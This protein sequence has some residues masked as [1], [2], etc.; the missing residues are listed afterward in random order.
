MSEIQAW[1]GDD[2]TVD[3]G[4]AGAREPRHT[5][6]E[7][8][9]RGSVIGRY[10][11]LSRLG[12][13]GM[14]VVYAAYDPELDRKV[15]LKLLLVQS[16]GTEGSEGTSGRTRLLREAQALAKVQHPNVVAIHDVG[17]HEGRVWLA[18]EHVMGRTLKA[19]C[20]ETPRP[21]PEVLDVIVRAGRG[22]AA[23]HAAGLL[24]RDLKPDN[25]MVSVDGRVRVMD[26]G[27]A[28]TRELRGSGDAVA[29]VGDVEPR[30]RFEALALRMTQAGSVLGTPAYMAPE[31]FLGQGVE[32]ATDQFSLCVTFWEALFGE[33]PFRGETLVGL[34]A[35]VLE[36]EVVAPPRGARVPS[37]LRR[38]V[39]RGLAV[40][41]EARWPSM[42]A[43]LDALAQGHEQVRRRRG[44]GLAGV[45]GLG[46]VA[47]FG[48]REI[49]RRDRIGECEAAGAT[50]AE[51]WHDD[52]RATLR[53]AL[54]GTGVSYA[55]VTAD[56]VLPWLDRHAQAWHAV[57]T[58][59]CLDA[60]A[61]RTWDA[62]VYDRALSCLD[63][64]RLE[65]EALVAELSRGE[66]ASVRKAVLAVAGL[67]R[68][69]LCAERDQLGW[70]PP[71]PV[72]HREQVREIRTELTRTT[73]AV[74]IWEHAADSTHALAA[75][76]FAL[77]RALWDA[78][79]ERD[80]AV[81]LATQARDAHRE[82]A[83]GHPTRSDLANA[84]AE[85]EKWLE[86]IHR[87]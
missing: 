57:R 3:A 12:A 20:E 38:V 31:Q 43:L 6:E 36:G 69:D 66:A 76:R 83:A 23:A 82:A 71:P 41:P 64:R 73:R 56:K 80:R 77:A 34:M 40:K 35:T 87:H 29:A 5:Q 74:A 1:S 19:W 72:Q 24:H 65:L 46:A 18:M 39:E 86:E 78:G 45:L 84:L 61:H 75:A 13:G 15:A 55:K 47:V 8:V 50:I 25:I 81:A 58:E 48:A 37:W 2:E 14:G 67:R 54:V 52:A 9:E 10:V 21:W 79:R 44:L 7:V 33:R 63:D 68:I 42:D 49:D 27:L 62:D 22:V 70:A 16:E 11:V 51:V 60:T 30:P 4:M 53:R 85:T 17:E 26:F 32:P 28:R 59:V